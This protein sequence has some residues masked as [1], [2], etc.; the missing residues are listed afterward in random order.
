MASYTSTGPAGANTEI[1]FAAVMAAHLIAEQTHPLMPNGAV[2]QKLS[3]QRRDGPDGFDD[4]VVEWRKGDTVGTVFIQSK[5]PIAISDNETFRGLA[6]A[7]AVCEH[8]GEWSAAIVATS[9]T[10][11]LEDIQVLLESA[12]LSTDHKEFDRK[13]EKPGVLNDAKRTVLKGFSSAVNGL[14]HDAA[15]SA[16]RRLRVVEHDLALPSSRDRQAAIEIL[17]KAVAEGAD[18]EANFEAIRS[19]FLETAALSPTFD[20]TSLVLNI[21][22]LAIRP[23]E[24]YRTTIDKIRAESRRAVSSIKDQI[25]GPSCSLTLLRPEC[26]SKLKEDFEAHRNVQLRGE[27]GSGKSALLKRYAATYDGNVLVLNE[28]RISGNIWAE[29]TANWGSPIAAKETIDTLALSGNCLLAIDGADRLLLDHRRSVVMDLLHAIAASPLRDRWSIITSGRDFGPQDV[30]LSA[31]A[32]AELEL[33][34]STI[35][36]ALDDQDLIIIGNAFP[37]VRSLIG[38]SDLANWN[39]NPFML[40]QLL[41]S[42]EF[43]SVLTEIELA[44]AWATRGAAATPPN[45]RRDSAVAQIGAS[46]IAS[47]AVIPGSAD[48]DAEGVATL[49]T[50]GSAQRQSLGNGIVLTHDVLEDWALAREMERNWQTLPEL[51]KAAGEPLWW[52]RAVRL[53]GQIKLE[54]GQLTEWQTLFTALEADED[55]DPAWAKLVLAAPLH[56]EK[57]AELLEQLTARLLD[58]EG[59]MLGALIEAVRT[60]ETRINQNI[61]TSP[62]LADLTQAERFY[63]ASFFKVPVLI[64]WLAFLRWSLPHWSSWP[65][66]HIPALVQLAEIWTNHYE[67]MSNWVSK[68]IAGHINNWLI[69]VEDYEHSENERG[70][71]SERA[72]P[73]ALDFRYDRWRELERDLQKVL[74][75]CTP[76]APEIVE[77]YLARITTEKRLRGARARLLEYPRQIPSQLPVAWTEMMAAALLPRERQRREGLLGPSSCFDSITSFHDA[78]IRDEFRFTDSSPHQLGWDQLFAKDANVALTMMHRLEMRAAVFWRN[79]EV[80]HEGRRPRALVLVLGDQELKLW[81]DETVYRWSR[82]ILGPHSLGSAYLALDNWLQEQLEDKASLAELLPRI[83]QNNGLVATTSPIINAVAHRQNDRPSI[84]AIAPLLAAPRL[85]GYDIRRHM[86]DRSPTHRIRGIGSGQHH[87]EAT[88]EI[89]ERY[90]NR[91]PFHHQLLLPFHLMADQEAQAFLQE[92]RIRWT[93]DDLA[94]FDHEL[95]NEAWR[96]ETQTRLERYLSD[97]D[98]QSVK[99]EESDDKNQILVRLEPPK[100]NAAELEAQSIE[101]ARTNSLSELA[102]W[103]ERSLEA[104]EVEGR[105]ELSDAIKLLNEQATDK[106][107]VATD[108]SGRMIQAASAGVAAVLAKFGPSELVETHVSWAQERLLVA[109]SRDRTPDEL[110]FLVPQS[111][112]SFDPQTIAAGGVAALVTRG[113]SNDLDEAVAEL[114]THQLHAVGSATLRGFEWAQRPEL[115]WRCLV[116]A[117]DTCVFDSGFDWEADRKKRRAERMNLKRHR[118]AVKFAT[119]RGP[120]RGPILPPKPFRTRWVRSKKLYPPVVRVK[121]RASRHFDWGKMKTLIEAVPYTALTAE[122]QRYLFEYFEGLTEWARSI[123]NEDERPGGYGNAFPYELVSTLAKETGRLAAI[124]GD[125]QA[126]R[127]LTDLEQRQYKGDLIGSYLDAVTHELIVSNRSPDDRFW[128]AWQ[129]AADWVMSNLVPRVQNDQWQNIDNALR[130]AGFVGPYMTPVPPDWPYL[131][132]LLPRIDS[133]VDAT[134]QHASAAHAVLAICERM[135]ADQ[136]EEWFVPWL[137]AYAKEHKTNASFWMYAGFSD[138]A[139]GLL[140]TLEDRSHAIRAQIRKT[141]SIMADAGSLSAREVLPL[142]TSNRPS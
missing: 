53:V 6:R 109:V 58:E 2:P 124:S 114:A 138:K 25:N 59:K 84:S 12:R 39:K 106:D 5:R 134:K 122:K 10:P 49:I 135:S 35:V 8:E 38:R 20:R 120:I 104:G 119:G 7:L 64:S 66:R 41:A 98:P 15:W 32:E 99:F 37:N 51:L 116:A 142:F 96:D 18:A 63:T 140:A 17:S 92:R 129:P 121:L 118:N 61:L 89:W 42:S 57:S 130:A 55:L 73:F 131:E 137:K 136:L 69:S 87:L 78:G 95:M 34:Q 88:E 94:D 83:L 43:P 101:Q 71:R 72:P 9:I 4:I 85:W 70:Y 29:V 82:A 86:D 111:V 48:I 56:S 1:S 27:A 24:R 50:E 79:R 33:G 23:Q 103:A 22:S 68:R 110:Q 75:M 132:M 46:R 113:F 14:D 31:F 139:A 133:W 102:T 44:D 112:M 76:S 74:S 45:Y 100:E 93:L 97:S 81:G 47:P 91:G 19:K 11:H 21:P 3:L 77:A 90:N 80:R 141:L 30:V 128:K 67:R 125:G 105:F 16:M 40:G 108:F 60:F 28:R 115:A 36:G 54:R 26:W 13:W 65:D 127:T 123:R 107:M 117:F 126:W 62:R 52:Q